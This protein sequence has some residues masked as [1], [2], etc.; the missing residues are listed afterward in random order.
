MKPEHWQQIDELFQ[1]V[2]ELEPERRGAFLD[3]ACTG[4]QALREEVEAMLA[5]DTDEWDLIERPA[6]E[7]AAPF[8]A[9]DH[10]QLAP[11]QHIAHY[12][13]VSL[14]GR[15]GMGEVYLA[16]DKTLNR[17]VALKLLPVDYIRD[18]NRWR[19]FQQEAHA[20]SAL[21]HPNIL[22]IHQLGLVDGQQFIATEF[23][24]GETL[25]QRMNR[26]MLS[27][28]EALDIA[29]QTASAVAAAHQA[30]IVHRDIKPEN[31]MLRPDGYVK[32]LDFGL[33]K[34]T[35]QH[36]RTL[37][38][39]VAD[40]LDTSSGLVMGTVK[41]MSPEQARGLSVDPR[42]DIFSLGV[43]L[44]E[45]VTGHAPFKGKDASA[46]IKSI[47]K[48]EPPALANYAP[49]L[50]DELARI[51][52]KALNKKRE[53]RYQTT[54]DL[55]ADLKGLKEE[56]DLESK[57]LQSTDPSLGPEGMALTR[58]AAAVSTGGARA[59]TAAPSVEYIISEIKR[60]KI[61]SLMALG[62][63]LLS[64]ATIGSVAYKFVRQSRSRVSGQDLTLTKVTNIGKAGEAAISPEGKYVAYVTSD[65]GKL[66]IWTRQVHTN[67]NVQLVPAL[68]GSCWGLTFSPDG[69][70]LY[71]SGSANEGPKAALFRVPTEGGV[72]TKLL[73]GVIN[74]WENPITFSPDGKHIAL[75]RENE[76]DE[77]AVVI[78]NANGTEE[79]KLATRMSPAAFVSLAWSP[80][81]DR[82]ACAV[83]NK[84]NKGFYGDLIEIVVQGG[85]EKSIT[86][87]RWDEITDVAWLSDG[88]SLVMAATDQIDHSSGIWEVSY[89]GG[90]PRRITHDLSNYSGLSLTAASNSLVTT[91]TNLIFNIWTQLSEDA[92]S[93]KQITTRTTA[94]DGW[95]GVSWTPEGRIVY[96]SDASGN[97]DI[98]IMEPDGSNQKQLTVDLGSGNLGLSVSSDGRY[99]VFV[100]HR[101]G[102]S[103]IWR[104]DIDGRNAKQLTN[105][106][107]EFNPV[108][109]PDGRWVGYLSNGAWWKIP[110]DGGE[111]IQ[112]TRAHPD[113]LT[114][115]PDGNLIAYFAPDERTHGKQIQIEVPG[116]G[117][118]KIIELPPTIFPRKIEWLPDGTALSYFVG[119]DGVDNLWVQPLDGSRAKQITDFKSEQIHKYSWSPDG[120]Q[121]AL[122]R[123]HSTSDIVMISNFR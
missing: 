52:N 23:V 95:G 71:Y 3:G 62:I 84:D 35:E 42:S 44:Y 34:L 102:N 30:G 115:S 41:Y 13:I 20:A 65:A 118:T 39:G 48:D 94:A 79:R 19:R 93:A 91:Q 111:A 66:S 47:L 85:P 56:L 99:I 10:P 5:S 26:G 78:A 68:A 97:A 113:W 117:T 50:P 63:L 122:A 6:L 86:D 76:R 49:A 61:W 25:R 59:A 64:T 29:T 100:S 112:F 120:K 101:A 31:I 7:A 27:L 28:R 40:T 51:L 69:D 81:G 98:W 16:K 114:I 96:S 119:V 22:T 106:N 90:D 105:G 36:Q 104:A 123:G 80:D 77:T 54:N 15:G 57:R 11:G 21:N 12:E 24:E 108:L 32:V 103:N 87:R 45:V 75:V 89:S 82:I 121:I 58:G 70:Y 38:A 43:V 109:G 8:V 110:I 9:D 88:S 55:F 2:V 72:P 107:G 53:N 60:H 1:T 74:V 46:L 92:G 73:T 18:K 116:H 83:R 17:R 33:A 37:K 4:D 67:R 14:I